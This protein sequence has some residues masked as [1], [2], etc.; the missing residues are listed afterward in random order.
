MDKSAF[1]VYQQQHHI[2]HSTHIFEYINIYQKNNIFIIFYEPNLTTY[3][4]LSPEE[5][6]YYFTGF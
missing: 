1:I 6:V 5:K 4:I 2:R 3:N